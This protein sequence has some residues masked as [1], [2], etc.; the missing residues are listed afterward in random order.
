M[1]G[2]FNIYADYFYCWRCGSHR[3]EPTLSRTLSIPV[4]AIKEIIGEYNSRKIIVGALNKKQ[5]SA[6]KSLELPGH[7]FTDVEM[8]YLLKRKFI[9]RHLAEH[10]GVVGGGVSGYWKF[11]IIIPLF[12]NNRLVSWTAR[13]ILSDEQ[14]KKSKQP[15]YKQLKVEESIIDPKRILY[16]IDHCTGNRLVLLEGA[17]DV[18][19]MGD[20]FA[21][22]F[23]TEMT[24]A[25]INYIRE[26]FSWVGVLFDAE[27]EAQQKARRY[28]LQLSALGISVETIDAFGDFGKK[29]AGE[30]SP[31]QALQLRR[32]LGFL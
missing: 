27:K 9:P 8:K 20:G 10:Y 30:L 6:R 24:Q 15:R 19:R 1:N 28:A 16:N 12:V 14:L 3:L 5:T 31:R 18:I 32:E 2:G 17:F 22:S 25:Q 23:G 21:C 4:A 7:G 11:R 29:D 13:S 26:R